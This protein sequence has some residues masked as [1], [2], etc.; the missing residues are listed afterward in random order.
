[1]RLHA[2]HHYMVLRDSGAVLA[3]AIVDEVRALSRR[4]RLVFVSLLAGLP[5][6]G[7]PDATI[8]SRWS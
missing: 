1:M 6:R 2:L 4:G 7:E 5:G 3:D 8:T